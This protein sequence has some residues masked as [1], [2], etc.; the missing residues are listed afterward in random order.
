MIKIYKNQIYQI[1]MKHYDLIAFLYRIMGI[2][3]YPR[4][5]IIATFYES[6]IMI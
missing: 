3:Y 4:C 5:D 1:T 6:I 2:E